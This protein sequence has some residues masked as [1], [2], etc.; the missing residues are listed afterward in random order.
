M[1]IAVLGTD[2]GVGKTVVTAGLTGWL[3][4]EGVDARAIKPVQTGYP[5]DDDA[6]FVAAA[7]K[8]EKA[9][10]CLEQLEPPLAPAVAAGE[11]G[12]PLDYGDLLAR[13]EQAIATTE[14]AILEGVG[15]LRVPLAENKEV[16]DLVADLGLSVLVVAR[17]GLGTINHTALTVEALKRRGIPICGVVLNEYEGKGVAERTNPETLRKMLDTPVET[18]STLDLTPPE[19]AITGVREE[20]SRTLVEPV[21]GSVDTG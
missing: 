9:A 20:L 1:S 8:S 19:A 18:L 12:K 21:N 10:T 6:A 2:T 17:S 13:C 3:R 14:Y 5:P 16:V 11:V 15:G 7:C 4:A